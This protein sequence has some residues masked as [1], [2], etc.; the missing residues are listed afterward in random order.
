[1]TNTDDD[2]IQNA[3]DRLCK[4]PGSLGVIE[5]LAHR[6]GTITGSTRPA[7]RPAAA[8]VFAADHG[9][10]ARGVS[11][12]PSSVTAAVTT[13]MAGGRTASGVFARTIDVDF[14]VV[15]VGLCSPIVA[16]E[17]H[18]VHFVDAAK[19]R[20][21]ADFSVGPAMDRETFDHAWQ[22][23]WSM[24]ETAARNDVKV[25]IGGEMGIGNT[26][27]A[28]CLTAWWTDAA[29]ADV[30]GPGAGLDDAG[31]R[32]KRDVV[33][34]TLV[35]VDTLGFDRATATADDARE[36]ARQIGGL[37]IVSLAGFYAAAAQRRV[38][39]LLDGFISTAAALVAETIR[40]G[41][42]NHMIAAHQ[43]TEPGHAAALAYLGLQPV[44]SMSMRLGEASGALAAMPML[45]LAAAMMRD[46]ATLDELG[47]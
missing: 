3:I 38:V 25:L 16:P 46:M 45:D 20:G 34:Q 18:E 8:V 7:V 29:V 28:S 11:A 17:I 44:L 14:T 32:R 9:V 37:E 2:P 39:V 12:W 36:I 23:G 13:L 10:T 42:K 26:T 31:I 15:D 1:M 6:L 41:T 43:S 30:V 40:P 35:R 5:R 22:T 33:T 19:V 4:P 21:T 47:K 27:A 24:V